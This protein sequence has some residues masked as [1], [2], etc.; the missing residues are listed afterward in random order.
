MKKSVLVT[1]AT[2]GTGFAIARRFAEEGYDVFIGSRTQERAQEA[3]AKITAE[4]GV[5]A[6]GYGMI[7]A[8]ESNVN[9][10]FADIADQ[11]YSLRCIVLNAA[12]L[13]IRQEA[14]TVDIEEFNWVFQ[15]NIIWNFMLARKAAQQ[16]KENGGGSIVFINSNTAYRAIPDRVAYSAS[17]SGVLGM[18]RALALDWGKYNI[19]VNC[20]LPG[21]IK[22]ER[23][24]T[25]YNDC[26][27]APSNYTPIGDIAD[28]EDIA[29]AAYFLGSE[30]A[31]NVTGAE[32]VVDGG[33]MIQ[34]YP[35]IPENPRS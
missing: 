29:N 10:I 31:K 18:S 27:N 1:G 3:A 24:E 30:Q 32:L 26:R 6:K 23:W 4:F 12:N 9:E 16:M 8:D 25:N 15:T 13:G 21:M 20:V 35:I 17:K 28:F 34:L 14:M 22:T 5:F 2:N 11:G 7:V 33:N 19:R